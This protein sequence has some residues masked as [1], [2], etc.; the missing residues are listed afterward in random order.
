VFEKGE[1]RESGMLRLGCD[2]LPSAFFMLSADCVGDIG[3]CIALIIVGLQGRILL[4]CLG[5]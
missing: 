2:V 1:A 3:K 5:I 4:M